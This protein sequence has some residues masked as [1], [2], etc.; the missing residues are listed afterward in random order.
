MPFIGRVTSPAPYL[1]YQTTVFDVIE[2]LIVNDSDHAF[3]TK[4]EKVVGIVSS[5]KL[6]EI[7]KSQDL[8]NAS[9]AE[10]L[11]PLICINEKAHKS[12]AASLMKENNV[13]HIA[14]TNQNG[15]LVGIASAKQLETES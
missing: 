6:L 3:I 11:S 12:I 2:Y 14:V 15:N 9:V 8:N 1:D 10:Y 13:E 4:E 7:Y 5:E